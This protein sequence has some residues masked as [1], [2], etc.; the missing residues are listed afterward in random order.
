MNLILQIF[1][2][3]SSIRILN[4]NSSTLIHRFNSST[5]NVCSQNKIPSLHWPLSMHNSHHL[6]PHANPLAPGYPP[7]R[8]VVAKRRRLTFGPL[9]DHKVFGLGTP[10][11]P[12]RKSQVGATLRLP[13]SRMCVRQGEAR[14]KTNWLGVGGWRKVWGV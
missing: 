10:S 4:L 6:S 9:T 1:K 12:R 2:F 14:G 11:Q 13:V 5:S 8:R 3:I 7:V